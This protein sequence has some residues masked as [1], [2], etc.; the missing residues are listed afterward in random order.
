[1]KQ[2]L[3]A[4]K[5]FV[6]SEAKMNE[7]FP[8]TPEINVKKR[9][10]QPIA[11]KPIQLSNQKQS[12]LETY[13]AN[14]EKDLSSKL[15]SSEDYNKRL[16]VKYDELVS[17][18]IKLESDVLMMKEKYRIVL[19]SNDETCTKLTNS[20]LVNSTLTR[21]VYQQNKAFRDIME[22]NNQLHTKLKKQTII[23]ID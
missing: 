13:L 19:K 21:E 17:K 11:P 7:V 23:Y 4:R 8:P 12:V 16:E 14:G 9:V 22:E 2:S 5:G 1:M 6:M 3:I 15:K 10:Y 20:I 18:C